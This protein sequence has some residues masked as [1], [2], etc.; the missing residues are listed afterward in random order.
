MREMIVSD[1]ADADVYG[2]PAAPFPAPSVTQGISDADM[3]LGSTPAPSSSGL[4]AFDNLLK[5]DVR[6]V[7][8]RGKASGDPALQYASHALDTMRDFTKGAIKH[9][10]K[11]LIG[12]DKAELSLFTAPADLVQ[13]G[14][15][16]LATWIGGEK[17]F[18]SAGFEQGAEFMDTHSPA[19]GKAISAVYGINTAPEGKEEEA[20]SRLVSLL[21][22]GLL[23]V[24]GDEAA[25]RSYQL[26]KAAGVPVNWRIAISSILGAGAQAASG[27]FSFSSAKA[28]KGLETISDRY[29]PKTPDEKPLNDKIAASFDELAK[30]A[31]A[32]ADAIAAHVAKADAGLG[33]LLRERV[34]K[35]QK[36]KP[37]E[38]GKKSAEAEIAVR[39]K[40]KVKIKASAVPT[41]EIVPKPKITA[42]AVLTPEQAGASV[43]SAVKEGYAALEQ[44]ASILPFPSRGLRP[45]QE[46]RGEFTS[47]FPYPEWVKSSA[48]RK[49]YWKGLSKEDQRAR[50]EYYNEKVEKPRPVP[51]RFPRGSRWYEDLGAIPGEPMYWL[52]SKESG[53]VNSS[54][55]VIIEREKGSKGK[56]KWEIMTK[57]GR[58]HGT[59]SSLDAAMKAA[60]TK[61]PNP[62]RANPALGKD[63]DDLHDKFGP[64]WGALK[65]ALNEEKAVEARGVISVLHLEARKDSPLKM[66]LGELKDH[67]TDDVII[68]PHEST[69]VSRGQEIERAGGLYDPTH[70]IIHLRMNMEGALRGESLLSTPHHLM[71]LIH[72]AV[73]AVTTR[74]I[75]ENP[76]HPLV[77]ELND[78]MHVVRTRMDELQAEANERGVYLGGATPRYQAGG[79]IAP[80]AK[81]EYG[82]YAEP[83]WGTLYGLTDGHELL[84][85]AR[86][87][88]QF[89][90]LLI[91]SSKFKKAYET[92]KDVVSKIG[93][94]IAE[95]LG[96]KDKSATK[97]LDNILSVGTKIM[98]AQSRGERHIGDTYIQK[99][100]PL[101]ED[102]VLYTQD[103]KKVTKG[104][105]ESAARFGDKLRNLPGVKIAEAKLG[106]FFEDIARLVAPEALGPEA[107]KTGAHLAKVVTTQM[108]KDTS[109]YHKSGIRRDF[110]N[111]QGEEASLDFIK[112]A[113]K[114]VVFPDK[115]VQALA[116]GYR[117]WGKEIY[118][119]DLKNG[120]DFYDPLDNYFYHTFKDSDGATRYISQRHGNKF[121]TPG[122]TK[123]RSFNLYEEAIA[124]GFTLRTTNPE[125]IM[126]M[127]QHASDV[128]EMKVNLFKDLEKSGLAVKIEKGKKE[129]S[130][131]EKAGQWT[132]PNGDRYLVHAKADAVLHNYFNTPSLWSHTRTPNKPLMNLA[133]PAFKGLM[134]LKN[135]IVPIKLGLS[136]FHF[137]HVLTIDNITGMVRATQ[138]LASGT[139]GPGAWMANMARSGLFLDSIQNPKMGGHIMRALK[140]QIPE[141]DLTAYD[142]LALQYMAE[143]GLIPTMSEQYRTNAITNLKT[144]IQQHSATALWHAPF[145]MIGLLQRPM[146]EVWIPNLKIASYLKDIETALKTDPSLLANPDARMM[147]FRKIAKS[148]DNRYGEMAYNTLFMNRMVKDLAVLNTLSLGWQMGIIREYGG[149]VLDTWRMITGPGSVRSKVAKGGLD[150]PMMVLFYTA[151]GAALIGLTSWALSGKPPSGMD[152]IYPRTAPPDEKGESPRANTMFFTREFVSLYDHMRDQG[153]VG[154]LSE[155]AMNKGSGVVGLI[156]EWGRGVNSYNEEIR[157]PNSG[158]FKKM[159][160]TLLATW[161][162]VEPISLSSINKGTGTAKEAGLAFLGFT[163]APKYI[164]D[165]PTASAI[166][167][168][169]RRYH[170]GGQTGYEHAQYSEDTRQLRKLYEDEKM[171]EYGDLIDKIEEKYKLSPTEVGKLEQGIM[172]GDDPLLKM[173]ERLDKN[174]KRRIL[175]KMT[176]EERD[177]F[178]P[179]AGSALEYDYEEAVAP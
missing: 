121:G 107:K 147:A 154:G 98:E 79:E 43:R 145:A 176:E 120:I 115:T 83:P 113:E 109:N 152:F 33:D 125:D 89:Q 26:M 16:G 101:P 157:D 174:E 88:P 139:M 140:G 47:K 28:A 146:F 179:H 80:Y 168:T 144:A 63:I 3:G 127:R 20:A 177:Y 96:I 76:L 59:F 137:V 22:E 119:Q 117:N 35:A 175:D 148:V 142:K 24:P 62:V 29:V 27:M 75:Q 82:A 173:F 162:A 103:G 9:P 108:Q 149:A 17:P 111:H 132:S 8:R 66:I 81:G 155:M 84:A 156:T 50:K 126:L 44:K 5:G 2:A 178:L 143:G 65:H 141:K 169:Y 159:E 114:G 165:S 136:A 104:E 74:F 85:E 97:L 54:K 73:H 71:T 52:D 150:R 1:L 153:V 122:F 172:R 112:K 57:G 21:P 87:N 10:I 102:P 39:T 32:T 92:L 13:E 163:P 42:R 170:A 36:T 60:E 106:V 34:D 25:Q 123:D 61:F 134:F 40:P 94:K 77:T 167:S 51:N 130:L 19:M 23:S 49:A 58:S 161:P 128:A 30:K 7:E 68:Q 67:L 38:I 4:G 55:A 131:G 48:D 86:A 160:Q 138:E 64:V 151:T 166:K 18:T 133:S 12:L 158:P 129:P 14:L 93:A 37:E 91:K 124:A 45:Y 70:N 90:N 72:E 135:S 105:V 56:S 116:E 15:A 99:A 41:R 110:W 95:V 11:S 69:I 171:D 31:P 164:T 100:A 118:L 6:F 78:L 53:G 46:I